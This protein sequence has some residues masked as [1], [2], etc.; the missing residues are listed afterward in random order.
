M[1]KM[2]FIILT[3]LGLAAAQTDVPVVQS[4]KYWGNS[5]GRWHEA[6]LLTWLNPAVTTGTEVVY[7]GLLDSLA[8]SNS[9]V[10]GPI[11]SWPY[12]SLCVEVGDSCAS[13]ADSVHIAKVSMFQWSDND[14]TK[15]TYI[16]DLTWK[17]HTNK[18]ASATM[19]D[20][21]GC[22]SSN[23]SDVG[24]YLPA[25]YT[26]LVFDLGAKS[27]GDAGNWI[28]VHLTGWNDTASGVSVK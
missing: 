2:V 13:P 11:Y 19:I 26:W 7:Y 3:M 27:K 28:K 4:R 9:L 24:A 18:T 17:S 14:Y 16:M 5:S 22:F 6:S 1:K 21:T 20:T 25:M 8:G 10:C 15:S 12:M 23:P